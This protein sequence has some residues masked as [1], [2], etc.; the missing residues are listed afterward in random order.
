M[1]SLKNEDIVV[2]VKDLNVSFGKKHV[3]KNVSLTVKSGE[4]I[5]IFG[6]SGAG[7]T[8]M[9]RVL[10]CQLGKKYWNGSVYVTNLSA[11]KKKN[12]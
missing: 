9:I 11:A 4:I 7:K 12:H 5:G 8:T 10:T 3:V 6:I 1:T 2:D